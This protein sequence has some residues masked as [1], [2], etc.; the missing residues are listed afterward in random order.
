MDAAQAVV[1]DDEEGHA[2]GLA[3]TLSSHDIPCQTVL[4]KGD[5]QDVTAIPDAQ[6]I[7]SDLHLIPGF[8]DPK[9]DFDVIAGLLRDSIKPTGPYAIFLWTRYP[10]DAE[11]L[12]QF[13]R[14]R[15]DDFPKPVSV[16]PL[17][18]LV[19]LDDTGHVRNEKALFD[20]VQM[21]ID[22]AKML[23]RNTPNPAKM[24]SVL[25]RLFGDPEATTSVSEMSGVQGLNVRLEEWMAQQLPSMEMT[26]KA[27]LES[28]DPGNLFLLERLVHSIATLRA[29]MHP[30][31]VRGIVQ[32][33][34]ERMY[35]DG[36]S[37][38]FI[39]GPQVGEER[40]PDSRRRWME[41]R[42]AFFGDR[43]PQEFFESNELDVP[44]LSG[45]SARLDAIDEGAFS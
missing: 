17:T 8:R 4:F 7:L 21:A 20:E 33:R 45:I 42:N 15:L 14:E 39:G 40:G 25:R 1:I 19:H 28:N 3:G 16:Y 38:E 22:E 34:V 29:A 6:F 24:E 30:Q 11:G 5:T 12:R 41:T 2:A 10:D 9:A 43:T 36:V 31:F 13:L 32:Q 35:D 18:K 26:P 44:C 27:M 37:L 23:I